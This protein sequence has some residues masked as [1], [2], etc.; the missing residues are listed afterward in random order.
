MCARRACNSAVAHTHSRQAG[1]PALHAR[2]GKRLE[3]GMRDR[4]ALDPIAKLHTTVATI[5]P[6]KLNSHTSPVGATVV[7]VGLHGRRLHDGR[8]RDA[9]SACLPSVRSPTPHKSKL[10]SP[11]A[12]RLHHPCAPRGDSH[13]CTSC[14]FREHRSAHLC[15]PVRAEDECVISSFSVNA[16]SRCHCQSRTQPA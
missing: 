6:R 1:A 16:A 10:A 4:C 7:D 2:P 9:P 3:C 12:N 15:A 14:T 5:V 8:H 13:A 11:R